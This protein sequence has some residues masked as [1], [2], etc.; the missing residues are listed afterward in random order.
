MDVLESTDQTVLE[1][2]DSTNISLNVNGMENNSV[3]YLVD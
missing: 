3:R 1:N 2:E